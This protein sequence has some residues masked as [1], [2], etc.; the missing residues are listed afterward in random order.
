VLAYVLGFKEH[1]DT[2]WKRDGWALMVRHDDKTYTVAD[3]W[4]SS[5][6]NDALKALDADHLEVVQWMTLERPQ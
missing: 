3:L 6:Y 2:R 5:R 4:S 1:N